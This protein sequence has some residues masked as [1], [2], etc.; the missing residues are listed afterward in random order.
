MKVCKGGASSRNNSKFSCT[1]YGIQC[2]LVS[3][4]LVLQLSLSCSSNLNSCNSSSKSSNTLSSLLSIEISLC[5]LCLSSD[6]CNTCFN[7]LFLLSISNNGRHFLCNNN[8]FSSSKHVK[9]NTVK[10]NS[11]FFCNVGGSSSDCDI[12]KIFLTSH[13]E[14]RCLDSYNIKNSS[15]FVH[16]KCR[17]CFTGNIL[18]HNKNWLLGLY[19]LFQKWYDFIYIINL[20]ISNQYSWVDKFC[21]LSFIILDKVWGYESSI[22]SQTFGEFNF[23]KKSL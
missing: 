17:K 9:G 22:N 11:Y 7:S 10:S 16:N 4:F 3:Q 19:K 15:H 14:T 1:I 20:C 12:L 23:I 8:T 2:I 6:L 21:N 5:I 13:S 18:S